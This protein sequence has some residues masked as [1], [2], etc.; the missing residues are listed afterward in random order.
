MENNIPIVEKQEYG[1]SFK[2]RF[3][4]TNVE[5]A[6][7]HTH[8]YGEIYRSNGSTLPEKQELIGSIDLE[9]CHLQQIQDI[10]FDIQEFI[11]C[12]INSQL[13]NIFDKKE[14]KLNTD[15][16]SIQTSNII[17]FNI[18][19]INNIFILP[20]YR[21]LQ[22]A[23]K[24][25]DLIKFKFKNSCGLIVGLVIPFQYSTYFNSHKF[26]KSN[27]AMKYSN[28]VD[29]TELAHFKILKYVVSMGF[30]VA[31]NISNKII[32]INTNDIDVKELSFDL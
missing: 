29:D 22:I 2:V 20:E 30:N 17:N 14:A 8:Y 11:E 21:G 16:L 3:D 27:T 7:L 23:A 24:I 4:M 25:I 10:D 6:F 15:F 19:I 9:M 13:E 1:I 28:F 18:L 32:Y 12:N 5:V 26:G 31:N